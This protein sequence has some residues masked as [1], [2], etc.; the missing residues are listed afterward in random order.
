MS[1]FV[2]AQYY[3][4]PFPEER[5]WRD[6]LARMADSGLGVV[7]L[8]VIWGWVEAEPDRWRFDDYDRLVEEA[9]R[10]GLRVL[11]STVAEIHPFW[12]HRLI[13][14]AHLVNHLGHPEHSGLRVEVNVGLTPGGCF[15]H[16]QVRDRIVA[17]LD[18]TSARYASAS[19]LLGWDCWNENRWNVQTSGYVCYCPHTLDAYRRW[20]AARY[21]DLA[22]LERAW[23]RR[24]ASWEDV[25]PPREGQR[26]YTDAAAF[27]RFL[28]DRAV[29]HMQLR[30]EAIRSNDTDHPITAHPAAP[31]VVD[32]GGGSEQ[33]LCRG[34]DWDHADRLDGYGCSHFP[35]WGGFDAAAYGIRIEAIRSAARTRPMW[36]SE[37]Q[38]GA[39]RDDGMGVRRGVTPAEQQRWLWGAI[40]RGAKGIVFWCWRDEVFG[41]ESSGFGLAGNDGFAE[42][43]LEALRWTGERLDGHAAL[44]ESWQPDPA[45]V[46]IFF[47]PTP[48]FLD[49][50]QTGSARRPVAH[51]SGYAAALE[52]L[53]VPYR[54]V[55]SAHLEDLDDL[56]LLLMPW[57]LVVPPEAAERIATFVHD[58]GTVLV[59]AECDA[60]SAEGFYRPPGERVFAG[61]LGVR[62]V[63]RRVPVGS[64]IGL[65][66]GDREHELR[67]DTLVTPLAIDEAEILGEH[68]GLPAAVRVRH[69]RGTVVVVGTWLG[70]AYHTDPYPDFEGFV[71]DLLD[72]SDAVPEVSVAVAGEASGLLWRTGTAGGER[73]L[74]VVAPERAGEVRVEIPSAW[75]TRERVE[76]VIP[77]P[78]AEGTRVGDRVSFI[79]PVDERGPG[80]YLLGPP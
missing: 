12:I 31:S 21:G 78:S 59:E 7:Q 73:V 35:A 69:G 75:L 62:D 25:M 5:H 63:G 58:G 32:T 36:V 76:S 79:A 40:A 11:L 55:E 27:L 30:F 52:R 23:H 70:A 57:T 54:F 71:A 18:R 77:G 3:R 42:E 20:L 64:S 74:F 10:V 17:F 37:L 22:G 72:V 50:S 61:S 29:E 46:G 15:D 51:R 8:W 19:N 65:R 60:F 6:D 38:G 13:P 68:A 53:G 80:I 39:A 4:P 49:W 56:D 24:Y 26:P 1:L 2:G 33:P 9:D 41:R 14:D 34:N 16:P 28:S 66:F 47:D 67:V 44:L 45:R 43:R 48:A